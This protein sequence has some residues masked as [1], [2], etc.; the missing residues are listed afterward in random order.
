MFHLLRMADSKDH[1]DVTIKIVRSSKNNYNDKKEN[2]ITD[3]VVNT[4]CK[5]HLPIWSS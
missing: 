5:L 4:F 2:I 3:N 1:I